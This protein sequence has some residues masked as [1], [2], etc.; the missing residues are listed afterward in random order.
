MKIKLAKS[1]WELIGTKA[2]WISKS[3]QI[4]K[5]A[6]RNIVNSRNHLSEF[7]K[8]AQ[9]LTSQEILSEVSTDTIQQA[10]SSSLH[11]Y[12]YGEH[13][14][15]YLRN[16]LTNEI[17]MPEEAKRVID[18]AAAISIQSKQ[19]KNILDLIFA[20]IKASRGFSL[21]VTMEDKKLT[22]SF[23]GVK[24]PLSA[25]ILLH[26]EV[27]KKAMISAGDNKATQRKKNV[28][29]K[30]R[31]QRPISSADEALEA[32]AAAGYIAGHI[33]LACVLQK[34]PNARS[35]QEGDLHALWRAWGMGL[36]ELTPD[37]WKAVAMC[38][39][40]FAN[41]SI[42]KKALTYFTT[43]TAEDRRILEE[44][45]RTEANFDVFLTRK[46]EIYTL[47]VNL[48]VINEYVNMTEEASHQNMLFRRTANVLTLLLGS[49]PMLNRVFDIVTRNMN[50]MPLIMK[51]Y[52]SSRAEAEQTAKEFFDKGVIGQPDI[53]PDINPN[54]P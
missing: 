7:Y 38:E 5:A 36:N 53:I 12:G 31:L 11:I 45:V 19:H 32:I 14:D 48:G 18:Q 4:Y 13:N 29:I 16:P 34:H 26:Q 33:T 47:A 51:E 43:I 30:P 40:G 8:K 1:Q 25:S 42:M 49:E 41:P 22:I 20:Y 10:I 15:F 3:Q 24:L 17:L 35:P 6:S 28:E 37:N 21:V 27:A 50:L 44:D 23:N 46:S 2:G 9:N 39:H 54:N 52:D